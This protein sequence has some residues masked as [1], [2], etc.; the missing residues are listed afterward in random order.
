MLKSIST[1][2]AVAAIGRSLA[3]ISAQIRC[4]PSTVP[5]WVAAGVVQCI[6]GY[7]QDLSNRARQFPRIH[8]LQPS[9]IMPMA[10]EP[11]RFLREYQ[12]PQAVIVLLDLLDVSVGSGP[13]PDRPSRG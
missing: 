4:H 13:I 2:R 12:F 7:V 9:A 6:K 10:L 3:L 5:T 8:G 1:D 11:R